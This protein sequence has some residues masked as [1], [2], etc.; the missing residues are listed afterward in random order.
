MQ[1][2]KEL[3]TFAN[4]SKYMSHDIVNELI[5]EMYRECINGLLTKIRVAKFYSI[6][7]DGTRDVAGREQLS[8]SIRWVSDVLEVHEDFIGMYDCPRAD[9]ESITS[10]ILDMLARCGLKVEHM[11]GQTYDGAAVLQ[12]RLTGVAKRN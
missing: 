11:R 9:A 8:L 4:T 6:I 7:V 1:K 5:L 3:E 12:G 2:T 10:T